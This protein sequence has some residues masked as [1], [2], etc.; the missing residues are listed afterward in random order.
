M[1]GSENWGKPRAMKDMNT[2]TMHTYLKDNNFKE[3]IY[4][5]FYNLMKAK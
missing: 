5:F 1:T 4:T 3:K 2:Y